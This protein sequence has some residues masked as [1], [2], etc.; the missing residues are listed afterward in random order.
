MSKLSGQ[1]RRLGANAQEEV[2]LLG[3]QRALVDQPLGEPF[4][5]LLE[6]VAD[7]HPAHQSGLDD[8]ARTRSTSR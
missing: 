4:P 2:A 7:A 6:L 1:W 5:D 3:P 8:R